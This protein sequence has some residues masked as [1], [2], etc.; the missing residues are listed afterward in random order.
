MKD[1]GCG[2]LA[3]GGLWVWGCVFVGGTGGVREWG[4]WKVM[5]G[6]YCT[7]VWDKEQEVRFDHLA[8]DK[9]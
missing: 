2:V 8:T 1:E 6:I 9:M 4:A 7:G 5:E 3:G